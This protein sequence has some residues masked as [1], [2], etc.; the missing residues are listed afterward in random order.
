[1]SSGRVFQ[2]RGPATGKA[3]LP[4]VE[5]LTGG[6]SRRLVP[7]ER[8]VRRPG[9]S[10]NG[11]R[12]PKYRG[13]LPLRTLYVS[14]ATLHSLLLYAG[15]SSSSASMSVPYFT[16]EPRSS[17]VRRGDSLTLRC[18]ASAT[19]ASPAA[20]STTIDEDDD[21]IITWTHNGAALH[22]LSSAAA[23]S[24]TLVTSRVH[25]SSFG[26]ADEG[27]YQCIASNAL[28]AVISRP[29]TLQ[30]ACQHITYL[31]V[32]LFEERRHFEVHVYM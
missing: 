20:E 16:L 32:C 30:L 17:V 5:S 28:G 31:L 11:T 2:T 12:G 26:A 21:L 23:V 24:A 3:R 19:A 10:A 9:R 27:L 13:A 22:N 18:T 14:T 25:L 7:A 29:A 4:T 6:T 1:M 15:I 8:N